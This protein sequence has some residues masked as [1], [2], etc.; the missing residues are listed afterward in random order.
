MANIIDGVKIAKLLKEKTRKEVEILKEKKIPVCL[1]VILVGEDKASKI[2]VKNKKKTCLEL[3]IESKEIILKENTKEKELFKIVEDLNKDK[4][5]NG[6]LV[7]LPLPKHL[8]EEKLINL[9]NP[10]KDVDC[11]NE[12]NVGKLLSKNNYFSPCTPSGIIEMLEYINY[13]IEG[14]NCVILGRSKIVGTPMALLMLKKNATVTICHSKT[15]N[16]EFF[17]KN[18]DILISAIGK[19]GFVKKEMVKKGAV[20]IDV[21]ISRLENGKIV[22]DVCFDEVFNVA[23][24]LTPVPGGVGPLTIAKL[25]ESVIVAAKIQN[26][27]LEY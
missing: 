3:G 16:L 5:V 6:I 26:N 20:V 18:A 22:G 8:S 1:A 21:G 23:S 15:L 2:Y 10:L 13:E 17:T 14:K 27:L 19:A 12:K 11:F 24:F 25:M 9:I 7:Q 4:S